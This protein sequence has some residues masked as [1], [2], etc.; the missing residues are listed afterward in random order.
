M[1]HVPIAFRRVKNHEEEVTVAGTTV[2]LHGY[3]EEYKHQLAFL[4]GLLGLPK[5]YMKR[6][7][8]AEAPEYYHSRVSP[9]VS[10]EDQKQRLL[11]KVR[12][13]KQS[14]RELVQAVG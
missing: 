3:A 2:E 14:Q 10:Y 9:D 11:D 6:H 12:S 13:G 8:R 4:R 1:P 5:T 7:L